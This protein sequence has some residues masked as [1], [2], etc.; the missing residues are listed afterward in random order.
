[1]NLT[2]KYKIHRLSPCLNK[3]EIEIISF[4]ENKLKGLKLVKKDEYPQYRFYVN[5]DDETI[6]QQS[7]TS[8]RLLIGY[9]G[10]W[11]VLETTYLLEYIDIQDIIRYM[12]LIHLKFRTSTPLSN[13][14]IVNQKL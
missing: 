6:L 2:R 4:I 3:K 1:M 7:I 10:F 9:K 11:E 8:D 13:I 5:S 14:Y 12:V